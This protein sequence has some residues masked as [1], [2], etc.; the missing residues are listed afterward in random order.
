VEAKRADEVS[1]CTKLYRTAR[2]ILS[3]YA[4]RWA[5]ERTVESFGQVL[6]LKD[7]T[8]RRPKA[9]DRTPPTALIV[10]GFAI[11]WF[12]QIGHQS[13]RLTFSPW[14]S[15]KQELPVA[16]VLTSLRRA[17]FHEQAEAP[18]TERCPF[19]TLIA[20]LTKHSEPDRLSELCPGFLD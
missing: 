17:S 9:V 5:I 7:P 4:R 19:K 3:A 10:C 8:N 11:V 6:G 15:K 12:H 18:S 14:Y 13:V 20:Q 2:Q 1:Y 16:D